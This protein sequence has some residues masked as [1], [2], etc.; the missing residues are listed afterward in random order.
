MNTIDILNRNNDVEKIYNIIDLISNK[1]GNASF[2]INGDWGS[3]KSFV[4]DILE[5]KLKTVQNEEIINKQ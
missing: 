2:A 1:R 3:G 4:L 5:E